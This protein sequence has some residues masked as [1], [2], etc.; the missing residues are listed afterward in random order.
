MT[1]EDYG[2]VLGGDEELLRR[3]YALCNQQP[4]DLDLMGTEPAPA[5][6]RA[7]TIAESVS[8]SGPGTFLGKEFRTI[9]LVPTEHEGWWIDRVDLPGSLPVRV[10][11]RNVWT[12]G[13]VVSNI[14]L[15]S[16]SPHNYIR[17]AEHIIALRMGCGIDNLIIQVESGDP[18]LFEKGSLDL[19]EAI[20]KAGRRE[21]DQPVRYVTVKE[22]VT[23]PGPNGS[24]LTLSPPPDGKPVLTVDCAV[25]FK[26]AIRKQRIRFPLNYDH[27]RHGAHART[28]TSAVKMLYVKTAGRIFAN[29]RNLGYT[30]RNI[31]IAGRFFYWNKPA[32]VHNG[33]SLEA[34]WHRAILDLLAAIALIENGMFVGE[35]TSYKA[36][37]WLDVQMVRQLVKRGLIEELDV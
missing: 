21:L 29:L 3:S 22:K 4:V 37:H 6:R 32:L 17:M 14:V 25:D 36:G 2:L 31:L 10:S 8:V 5:R 33:K 30:S 15:R 19:V 26:T 13:A 23:L 11:I 34:V 24:F 12:T 16:G 20:E 1:E 18:P 9:T 7:A 35:I 28:N 27:F